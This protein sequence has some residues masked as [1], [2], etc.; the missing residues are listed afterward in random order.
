MPPK[1]RWRSL[2]NIGNRMFPAKPCGG[3]TN[4]VSTFFP[5]PGSKGSIM[6]CQ[7]Y[8]ARLCDYAAMALRSVASIGAALNFANITDIFFQTKYCSIPLNPD[9]P[10]LEYLALSSQA[11]L[12]APYAVLR[13]P[14]AMPPPLGRRCR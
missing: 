9:I 10:R 8:L 11:R 7:P 13:R 2:R 3:M 12:N 6:V 4:S 1:R 14:P 5:L